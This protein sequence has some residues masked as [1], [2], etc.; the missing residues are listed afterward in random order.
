MG[1]KKIILLVTS[2]VVLVTV[3]TISYVSGW[4]ITLQAPESSAPG[5]QEAP[6]S[7]G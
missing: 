1:K 7:Y 4:R 5:L 3:G 2:I 6:Q